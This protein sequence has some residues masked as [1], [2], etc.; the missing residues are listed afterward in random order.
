[1]KA[2][3]E[4]D[5][6][7]SYVALLLEEQ[8]YEEALPILGSLM[9][10]NPSD[11]ESRMYRLL[12]LRILVQRHYLSDPIHHQPT[13]NPQ[14]IGNGVLATLAAASYE[15]FRWLGRICR[16]TPPLLAKTATNRLTISVA[17]CGALVTPLAF[18][19]GGGYGIQQRSQASFVDAS[20]L[21]S[22]AV[23]LKRYEPKMATAE[24]ELARD[25]GPW[26]VAQP[27]SVD[28]HLKLPVVSW[29]EILPFQNL[30]RVERRSRTASAN[31]V[32]HFETRRAVPK[33][34]EFLRATNIQ[35]KKTI[36]KES[37]PHTALA[38][39]QSQRTVPVRQSAS[40]AA[41]VVQE[42]ATGTLVSVVEVRGS[43]A[44]VEIAD[45][46]ITGFVR[47]EFLTPVNLGRVVES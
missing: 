22:S 27:A 16:A 9:D 10:M 26:N 12:V 13:R 24:P 33:R 2:V 41:G 1:M 28:T 8:R 47:T 21:T 32:R 45:R 39:Y 46:G 30:A 11:R 23:D 4:F 44:K 17:A 7:L 15:P 42:I 6:T 34:G 31:R 43:W 35:K 29:T 18:F 36:G 3:P 38:Q 20:Y 40:F 25:V 37:R 14:L 19:I 5:V